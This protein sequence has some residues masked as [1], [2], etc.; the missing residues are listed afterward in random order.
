MWWKN[1][2][3]NVFLFNLGQDFSE[4]I[5]FVEIITS[6]GYR[7]LSS[8]IFSIPAPWNLKSNRFINKA[9][10][11]NAYSFHVLKKF[12]AKFIKI[13]LYFNLYLIFNLNYVPTCSFAVRYCRVGGGGG[14]TGGTHISVLEPAGV[15]A[16]VETRGD[17]LDRQEAD[18]VRR[19]LK[20]RCNNR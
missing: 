18:L 2:F 16:E 15:H 20:Y 12:L 6:L 8:L 11:R 3:K 13:S 9:F 7:K 19:T 10:Q 1:G 5:A 14:S 17:P 4:S